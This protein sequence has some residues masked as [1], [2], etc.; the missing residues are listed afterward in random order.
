MKFL[1]SILLTLIILGNAIKVSLTY[2]WYVL[3]INSFVEQLCENKD[4]PELQCDGKCYLAKVSEENSS[5][6]Q[7][8]KTVKIDKENLL[9]NTVDLEI[10]Y[11]TICSNVHSTNYNY[12]NFYT[13]GFNYSIF[14][15]PR[16]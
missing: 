2:S 15:P 4:K 7:K 9:F 12:L 10:S 3:D 11:T 5:E 1:L 8:E 14:H 6:P 13:E 16:V